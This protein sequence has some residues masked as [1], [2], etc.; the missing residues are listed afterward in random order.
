MQT[1]ESETLVMG[2]RIC[3][4]AAFP[5]ILGQAQGW[6]RSSGICPGSVCPWVGDSLRFHFHMCK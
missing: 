2:L 4:V 5:V 3:V 1:S 6:E